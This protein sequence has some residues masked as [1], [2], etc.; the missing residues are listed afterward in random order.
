MISVFR[1]I[2]S[3]R[4]QLINIFGSTLPLK[5]NDAYDS[6]RSRQ[7]NVVIEES[8]KAKPAHPLEF[9]FGT[10]KGKGNGHFEG[11]KDFVY[12]EELDISPDEAARGWLYYKQK[13]WNPARNNANFHSEIGYIRMPGMTDKVE[14]VLAQ[15][16]GIA[17]I[18]EGRLKGKTLTLT[19]KCIARS[20]TS[21]PP[22]VTEFRRTWTVDLNDN[23]LTYTFDMATSDKPMA[24]HLS[25]ILYKV[26]K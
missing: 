4:K 12:D 6:K 15:P 21:K 9:L 3:S 2:N 23:V 18:E 24:P 1:T 8:L 22:H 25:A 26:S 14:L 5:F 20:S 17:S 16:T 10:W 11:I 13:T 19:S 7:Y